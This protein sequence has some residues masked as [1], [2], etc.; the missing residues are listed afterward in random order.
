MMLFL[1]LGGHVAGLEVQLPLAA[2]LNATPF[3]SGC[4]CLINIKSQLGDAHVQHVSTNQKI[5][6]KKLL[7]T[8]FSDTGKLFW[9]KV[10]TI[11]FNQMQ[12]GYSCCST[13]IHSACVLALGC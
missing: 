4:V 13:E 10:V 1:L 5:Q 7:D 2:T 11:T 9:H 8:K 6:K 3:W 12:L